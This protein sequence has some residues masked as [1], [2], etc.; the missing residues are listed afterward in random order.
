[1]TADA[2]HALH[3]G[4][5]ILILPNAWD[6]MSA[7]LIEAAGAEAVATSSAAVAWSHGYADGHHLPF[8]HLCDTVRAIVRVVRVPVTVDSEGGYAPA[9]AA[10]AENIRRLIDLGA[11]GVNLEDGREEHDLHL[12]KVTAVRTAAE[13]A[14]VNLFVNARTDVYLKALVPAGE[15]LAE[16]LRRITR[17]RDAGASGAFVPGAPAAD[18]PALVKEQPLPLNVMGWTGVPKAADLQ[19]MGVRRLS[20]ATNIARA[21]WAAANAA[22][23]AF[24]DGGDSEALTARGEPGADYNALF[25][26]KP[27]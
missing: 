2:F 22:A 26:F 19:A 3:A 23:K 17:L 12:A 1:M 7:K 9:P 16:A 25:R 20:A 11:A 15:R 14:G 13:K 21:A 6:A 4:P 5:Q 8:A 24:L 10:V 18:I 27:Q